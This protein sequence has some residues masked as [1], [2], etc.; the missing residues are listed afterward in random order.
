MAIG[1]IQI[2]DMAWLG[3]PADPVGSFQKGMNLAEQKQRMDQSADMHPLKM[4]DMAS[5]TAARD[6]S[7]NL[8]KQSYEY[9]QKTMDT[10]VQGAKYST[11]LLGQQVEYGKKTMGFRVADAGSLASLRDAQAKVAQGSIEADK[12]LRRATADLAKTRRDIARDTKESAINAQRAANYDTVLKYNTAKTTNESDIARSKAISKMTQLQA[13]YA[14]STQDAR[15]L[16]SLYDMYHG[17]ARADHQQWRNN[18]E[19][20]THQRNEASRNQMQDDIAFMHAADRN[21]W[22]S[23]VAEFNPHS[24]LTSDQK[25]EVLNVKTRLMGKAAYSRYK[26]ERDMGDVQKIDTQSSADATVG[27]IASR[28]IQAEFRNNPDFQVNGVYT[29]EGLAAIDRYVEGQALK[30]EISEEEFDR[31][32]ANPTATAQ[33]PTRAAM[34]SGKAPALPIRSKEYLGGSL[35]IPEE[36]ALKEMRKMYAQNQAAYKSQF[37]PEEASWSKYG[38]KVTAKSGEVYKREQA[39]KKLDNVAKMLTSEAYLDKF[40]DNIEDAMASAFLSTDMVMGDVPVIR[41][42]S[43]VAGLVSSGRL[44]QGDL[45]WSTTKK[46]W[47]RVPTAGQPQQQGQPTTGGPVAPPV[48]PE[49]FSREELIRA[50]GMDESTANLMDS[51]GIEWTNSSDTPEK[52]ISKEIEK[53]KRELFKLNPETRALVTGMESDIGMERHEGNKPLIHRLLGLKWGKTPAEKASQLRKAEELS[54]KLETL[55]QELLRITIPPLPK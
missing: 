13:D 47:A 5:A 27:K 6:A 11:S 32:V 25:Q 36:N 53:T 50:A 41:N 26:M 54:N 37:T 10:R 46:N 43:D 9:G 4:A 17:M 7:T 44:S 49:N 18:N 12:D 38:I 40:N 29:P 14:S 8:A 24:S 23:D 16:S 21:G 34:I 3:K 35:V 2:N 33:N 51:F 20:D 19:F 52:L 45:Y 15:V 31:L 39:D 22:L 48:D 55:N 30:A 28:A 1:P 42:P